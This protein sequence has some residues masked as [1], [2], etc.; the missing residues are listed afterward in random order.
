MV[1]PKKKKKSCLL[2]IKFSYIHKYAIKKQILPNKTFITNVCLAFIKKDILSNAIKILT[3]SLCDMENLTLDRY[4]PDEV[5]FR[6]EKR[7]V[8]PQSPF[9][10]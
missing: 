7:S 8:V 10:V 3:Q 6:Q 5:S 4:Q 1:W 2:N 9:S